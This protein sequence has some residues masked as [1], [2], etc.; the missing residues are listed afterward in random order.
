MEL[1]KYITSQSVELLRSSIR[2]ADYNPRKIT[3]E[4]RKTL[5]RGI[6]KFGLAGGIIVN[7]RTNNTIVSGH[8]RIAVLD[9]LQKYNAETKEN[10]YKI[11][12]DLVDLDEKEE[13]ELNI[14]TNNPNA[15]G[16]WDFDTLASIIPDIDYKTAGLTE[17]DLSMIG[18]D[19]LFKTEEENDLSTAL[20]DLMEETNTLHQQ[21]VQARKEQRNVQQREA[22][23]KA[24]E[25]AKEEQKSYDERKQEMKDLKQ[26]VK[27]EAQEKAMEMNAYVMLSFDTFEAKADFLKS[28]GLDPYAKFIKGETISSMLEDVPQDEDDMTEN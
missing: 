19:Y 12:V 15:Q 26:R 2:Y 23:E 4:N 22:I 11:R 6:K 25:A 28:F 1:S 20:D 21:E 3:D 13:K 16:E 7:K 18:V 8:Q 9:E 17:A 14:L 27:E 5:K 10:D 24:Q